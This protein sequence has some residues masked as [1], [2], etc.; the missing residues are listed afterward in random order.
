[1]AKNTGK[2]GEFCQS[3]KVRTLCK[4]T[5]MLPNLQN[6]KKLEYNVTNSHVHVKHKLDETV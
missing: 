4:W 1:M 6:V 2:V 3:G 5:F